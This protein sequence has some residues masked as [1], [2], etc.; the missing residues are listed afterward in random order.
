[1]KP[2]RLLPLAIVLATICAVGQD[3]VLHRNLYGVSSN[4]QSLNLYPYSMDR[5]PIGLQVNHGS[6]FLQR[7]VEYGPGSNDGI[8]LTGSV[9][10]IHLIMTNPNPREI[11]K[12]QLTVHGY[13]DKWKA[14]PLVRA[15]S[16]P[17]LAK[18][19]TVVLDIQGNGHASSD[20]SLNNFTAVTSV[21]LDSLTY[22]D[23]SAWEAASR[24]LCTVA[25]S[26]MMLVSA[27]R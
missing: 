21:D 10:R 11:V 15:S 17:D 5:C 20:L 3:V 9:Q 19:V 1:M 24:G 14:I 6:F 25:P 2:I 4:S 22:A 7:K 23:G 8:P 18:E 16:A 26:L 12:V 27:E 13:S